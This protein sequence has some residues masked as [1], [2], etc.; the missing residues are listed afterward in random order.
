MTV[1]ISGKKSVNYPGGNGGHQ[2]SGI[3][4]RGGTPHWTVVDEPAAP[5]G[6]FTGVL[7]TPG[8]TYGTGGKGTPSTTMGARTN[9]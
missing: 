3:D 4:R 6:V 7:C 9:A 5:Q 2:E 1:S 8:C